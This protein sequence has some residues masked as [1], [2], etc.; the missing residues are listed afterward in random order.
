MVTG[1]SVFRKLDLVGIE[2]AGG[3]CVAAVA[4]AAVFAWFSSNRSRVGRI[5]SVGC[6]GFIDSLIDNIFDGLFYDSD[7][8]DW[9]DEI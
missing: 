6:N 7:P 5:F 4:S 8:G 9:S 2:E 3:V 1:N